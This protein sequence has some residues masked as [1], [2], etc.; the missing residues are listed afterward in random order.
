MIRYPWDKLTPREIWEALASAPKVAGP[1]VPDSNANYPNGRVAGLPRP[2]AR[3]DAYG[4]EVALD[5]LNG[6]GEELV[7]IYDTDRAEPDLVDDD[8]DGIGECFDGPNARAAAD[9]RLRELGWL[10]CDDEP[11]ASPASGTDAPAEVPSSESTQE[12]VAYA[13]NAEKLRVDGDGLGWID[14]AWLSEW[15]AKMSTAAK[16]EPS[17]RQYAEWLRSWTC[18]GCAAGYPI[19]LDGRVVCGKC[20]TVTGSIDGPSE[21]GGQP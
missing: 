14:R 4:E 6:D 20:K 15:R 13:R 3:H 5:Y 17:K 8:G 10:L 19:L 7:N 18:N 1:W 9:A 11:A 2:M 21:K 16:G 12:E